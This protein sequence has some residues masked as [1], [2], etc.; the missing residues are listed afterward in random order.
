MVAALPSLVGS[1]T[2]L[3]LLATGSVARDVLVGVGIAI[4]L[5]VLYYVLVLRPARRPPPRRESNE[6]PPRND[7]GN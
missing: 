1:G 4:V 6:A 2:V 3:V 7:T 5:F